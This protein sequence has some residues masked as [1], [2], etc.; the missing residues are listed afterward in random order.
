MEEYVIGYDLD[1][2]MSQI[3]WRSLGEERDKQETYAVPFLLCKKYQVNQWSYGEAARADKIAGKGTVPEHLL[4]KALK[5]E[6]VLLEGE[7]YDGTELVLLFV[8]KTLELLWQKIR[9]EQAVAFM[10]TVERLDKDMV[11]LLNRIVLEIGE[12]G[13]DVYYQS[14]Q[15]SFYQYVIHQPQEIWT[16]DVLALEY[17]A[18]Y[19]KIY[20]MKL[21]KGTTPMV[22]FIE[23]KEFP[24]MN[25]CTLKEEGWQEREDQRFYEFMEEILKGSFISSIYLIGDGFQGNWM[26]KTLD[27]ICHR[28]RVF[29]GKNLYA[30]GASMAAREKVRPDELV[31]KYIFLGKDRLKANVGMNLY[32]QGEESYYPLADGGQNWY[33]TKKEW[34]LILEEGEAVSLMITPL[35]GKEVRN[36][37]IILRGLPKRPKRATRIKMHLAF[38]TEQKMIIQIED[39]GFGEM[40][41]SSGMRWTE[42]IEI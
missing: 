31:D 20:H 5:G 19:L 1:S 39:L 35:N 37:N 41:P 23:N 14:H 13:R 38:E 10:F 28:R 25:L 26:K 6:K 22:A 18:P 9:K 40:F 16:K 29:M 27:L 42:E 2:T 24:Q 21:N 17:I 32:I 11:K 7:A 3:T 12:M 33:E 15:E 4:E 8:K 36:V 30:I 34:D